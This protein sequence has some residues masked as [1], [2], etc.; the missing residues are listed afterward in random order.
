M[1]E[2]QFFCSRKERE[3]VGIMSFI[4]AALCV[5][6]VAILVALLTPRDIFIIGELWG[7]DLNRCRLIVGSG[8]LAFF[9]ALLATRHLICRN[10]RQ[11][12]RYG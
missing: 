11:R 9:P 4:A 10:C 1:S 5:I 12:R 7:F 3:L 8:I 6:L 2:I